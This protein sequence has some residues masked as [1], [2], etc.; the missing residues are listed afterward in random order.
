MVPW[1]NGHFRFCMKPIYL[2]NAAGAPIDPRIAREVVRGMKLV[3]NPSAFNDPGRVAFAELQKARLAVAR[4]LG[5]HL[6]EVIFT[7]SGSESNTLAVIGSV[8][9]SDRDAS[10]IITTAIEHRSVLEPIAELKRNGHT[11]TIL[12]VN[13]EGFVSVK[14]LEEALTSETVLV[15]VMYANNEIGTIQPIVAIGKAVAAFRK[16]NN[17]VYPLFHV[18]ACQATEYL[19]MNVRRLG[20]D[21]LSLNA[22]K[23]HGPRGIAALY[24]RKGVKLV[25]QILGGGQEHGIR[26]GTENLPGILGFAKALSL[27]KPSQATFIRKLQDFCIYELQKALPEMK[28]NGPQGEERLANNIN[29]SIPDFQS[30]Q[31]LLELDKEGI[32]AGSGSACT[33]RSVEP[34]HVLKAIGN[35]H[36]YLDGTLRFSLSRET[37][38]QDIRHL[39]RVM[40]EIVKRLRKRYEK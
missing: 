9:G 35:G 24:I 38:R 39:I 2:D 5:A 29:I 37:T 11:I 18:D 40:P 28:F 8:E 33:A 19:P 23:A 25:P 31:L 16:K 14:T 3:G 1:P 12:P 17:S 34:S 26:A 22:S 7:S 10:N 13:G 15:S 27:V 20:A 36:P 6:E 30:E 4:F 32:A 21:L